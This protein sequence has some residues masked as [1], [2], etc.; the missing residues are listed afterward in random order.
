MITVTYH[1]GSNGFRNIYWDGT[2]A[3]SFTGAVYNGAKFNAFNIGY[4]TVFT[5]RN[6]SGLISDVAVWNTPLTAHQ[7]SAI[8]DA[9]GVLAPQPHR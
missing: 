2:L 8:Y 7:I 1:G 5:G 9:R 6:Y 4:S 3:A